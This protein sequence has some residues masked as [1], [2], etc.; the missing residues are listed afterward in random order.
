MQEMERSRLARD[1]HDSLS[2]QL[3]AARFLLSSLSKRGI[4]PEVADVLESAEGALEVILGQMRGVCNQ[5]MPMTLG[6]FGLVEALRELCVWWEK[7]GLVRCVFH[8]AVLPVLDQRLEIDLFRV[9][10]EFITNS[11][12]HGQ[13]TMVELGLQGRG[14]GVAMRLKDN[15]KGFELATAQGG[16]MGIRNMH[17]R[18]KSHGGTLRLRSRPGAGTEAKIDV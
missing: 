12:R 16:G 2:Q 13:A 10:Q 8:A 15:G 18:I 17:S 4:P 11:V 9:C 7:T 1:V 14:A 5:L 6:D 3:T